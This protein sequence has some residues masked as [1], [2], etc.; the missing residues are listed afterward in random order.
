MEKETVALLVHNQAE[1][2]QALAAALRNSGI[3]VR[4]AQTVRAA[5]RELDRASAP[6]LVFTDST[7]PD[8]KWNEVVALVTRAAQPVNVIVVARS[9]D[10]KFYIE[11]LE[12][13]AFDFIVPPVAPADLAYIVR[14]AIDNASARRETAAHTPLPGGQSLFAPITPPPGNAETQGTDKT[15]DSLS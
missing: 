2:M 15:S 3:R 9:V 6:H 7:L 4:E 1:H 13:G 8:G 5:A 12:G 10:I 14:C 11:V